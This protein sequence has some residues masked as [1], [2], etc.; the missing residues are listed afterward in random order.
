[1]RKNTPLLFLILFIGGISCNSNSSTQCELKTIKTLFT[2]EGI[3][4]G[5]ITGYTHYILI[6]DFS[7]KCID[8]TTMVNMAL[9]YIDTVS[10]GRPADVLMFFNSDKDFIPNETSQVMKEINKSCLVVIGFDERTRKPNDFIFYN[11]KGERIY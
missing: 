11:E 5:K 6:K 2:T 10:V 9:K 8:S 7:K 4:E 3:Y 1:M